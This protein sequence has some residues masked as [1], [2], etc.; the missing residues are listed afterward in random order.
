MFESI[1]GKRVLVTGASSGIGEATAKIFSEH[2]AL[3]GVHYNAN[4]KAAREVAE[5]CRKKAGRAEIFQADLTRKKAGENLIKTFVKKFGG[6]DVLVNN[7]GSCREYKHWNE[8]NENDLDETFTLHAKAPFFLMQEAFKDMKKR[9]WGRIINVS[10]VSIKHAGTQNMHYY[11]SKAALEAMAKGLVRE[12][13]KHNVLVN[14]VRCGIIDTPMR[15]KIRGYPGNNDPKKLAERIAL[16]P[17]NRMGQPDE[18]AR[19]VLFLAS[20]GG[21]FITGETFSVAGGE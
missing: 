11:S 10:T 7:A 17:L 19:M 2:G 15:S 6:I 5:Y 8:L 12:G 18:V 9:K 16:V 1:K 3:V 20:A 21:D 4:L 14:V 13:V